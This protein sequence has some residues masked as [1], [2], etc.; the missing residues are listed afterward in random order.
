ME[1]FD[2]DE[3]NIN[4]NKVKHSVNVR[5]CEQVFFDNK[6]LIVKDPLHSTS[7]ERFY[8]FGSTKKGRYLIVVF[9]KRGNKTRVISARDQDKKER[10]IY[11]NQKTN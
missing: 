11:E 10:N 8:A 4:K 5:E 3:G 9:T 2:W 1:G 6:V 7:E